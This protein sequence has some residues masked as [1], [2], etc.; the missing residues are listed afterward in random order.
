MSKFDKD[1]TEDK[2]IL[3]CSKRLLKILLANMYD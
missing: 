3:S 1:N 2:L